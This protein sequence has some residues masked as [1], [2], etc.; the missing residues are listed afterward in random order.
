[1]SGSEPDP[2]L[3]GGRVVAP[4]GDHDLAVAQRPVAHHHPVVGVVGEPVVCNVKQRERPARFARAR[5][6]SKRTVN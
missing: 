5:A 3:A 2:V 1:M 4:G 6:S